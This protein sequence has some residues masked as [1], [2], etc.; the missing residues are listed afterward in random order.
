MTIARPFASISSFLRAPADEGGGGGAAGDGGGGSGGQ[1]G[2]DGGGAPPT[3]PE[4]V[5]EKFWAADKN[6]VNVE[7]LAKSYTELEGRQRT[8][9]E[10]L[11]RQAQ[12]EFETE[13]RKGLPEKPEGYKLELP[14]GATLKVPDSDPFIAAARAFAHKEGLGQQHFNTMV[15]A[16]VAGMMALIPDGKVEMGKLGDKATDRVSAVEAYVKANVPAEF[17]EAYEEVASTAAGVQLLEHLIEKARPPSQGGG[18]EGGAGGAVKTPAE[19]AQMRADPR[20]QYGGA[21]FDQKYFDMVRAEYARAHPG[22]Q[23]RR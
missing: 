1:G 18:G 8:S 4:F 21:K 12:T 10:E 23:G 6:E 15:A 22:A 17:H 9:K 11:K 13:R 2:G 3:R 5:P 19:L 16:H 14:D 20:Y 7:A